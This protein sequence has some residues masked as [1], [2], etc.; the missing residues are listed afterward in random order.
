MMIEAMQWV[1]RSIPRR[2]KAKVEARYQALYGAAWER[3]RG[4]LPEGYDDSLRKL[5][6]R[7]VDAEHEATRLTEYRRAEDAA[8]AA[9]ARLTTELRWHISNI[10]D[11]AMEDPTVEIAWLQPGKPS[12][13]LVGE[14]NAMS[15]G[16]RGAIVTPAIRT[17]ED[18]N[19]ALHELGHQRRYVVRTLEGE[20]AAWEWAMSHAL[21]WDWPRHAYMS[22]NLMSYAT[23][24]TKQSDVFGVQAIEQ[25]CT[26]ETFQRYERP[27]TEAMLQDFE[28]RLF[29]RD[30]GRVRVNRAAGVPR[31]RSPR[32]RM[33]N[34]WCATPAPWR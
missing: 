8:T 21:Y 33:P 17:I 27:K 3:N 25:M 11:L 22:R 32:R 19:A 30:H 24:A 12:T 23:A 1:D 9:G 13:K 5:A 2:R 4:R 29:E 20:V 16:A 34:G 28:A 26:P 7:Q 15:F 6:A 14:G 31:E 10:I 18:V